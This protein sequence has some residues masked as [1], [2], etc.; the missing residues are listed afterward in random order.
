MMQRI[1][2]PE[3]IV[4]FLV[5]SLA[6][7]AC[8]TH[9][10]ASLTHQNFST[11]YRPEEKL[12]RPHY[13]L[14]NITDSMTRLYFTISNSELLYT[15]SGPEEEYSAKILLSYFV[16][17][18][19]F[20]KMITDSGHVVMN[21]ISKPGEKKQLAAFVDMDIYPR[22]YF[23][24]EVTMRD[25]NKAAI[26]YAMLHLDHRKG[27]SENNFLASMPGTETPLFKNHLD[28][29]ESFSVHYHDPKITR[30]MVR[31]YVNREGPAPP[32]YAMIKSPAPPAAD[33]SWW[34]DLDSSVPLKLAKEGY[35]R[36]TTDS[37][38]N[39][40][41]LLSRFYP[42]FPEITEA[43]Q[44]LYPLRYLLMRQEYVS[45][46]SARNT[47]KAVDKFWLD[48]SGSEER[49][50]ELIRNYYNRVAAANTL[51]TTVKE[52]WK[53][54]RGMVYL[55]FGPPSSVYRNSTSET[56]IYNN[57]MGGS[58][59]SFAFDYTENAAGGEEDYILARSANYKIIW[60]S[61]VD[62]W[63]QGHVYTLH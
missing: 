25:L 8:R 9:S 34:I 27:E 12:M 26:T 22:G 42:G 40:G 6:I 3:L 30:L 35:Y 63:R 2:R 38:S 33:S 23:T 1:L 54:D 13:V 43:K 57:D 55:I 16:H 52:G 62:A 45:M 5:A 53:T 56:W 32:P 41:L 24:V 14:Y 11:Y 61:A 51:F 10:P 46:D 60:I 58:G 36:F 29:G 49:A 44:L 17:P 59:V 50:R 20:P 37:L 15:K 28:S 21:D 39:E 7:P 47:K 48:A 4:F 18:V 31:Y 19:E